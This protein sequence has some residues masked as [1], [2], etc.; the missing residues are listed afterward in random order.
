[1]PRELVPVYIQLPKE[2]NQRIIE[3]ARTHG[4]SKSAYIRQI[5]RIYL[6]YL[7]RKANPEREPIVDW[8]VRI[9]GV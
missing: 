3:L 4:Y 7:D 5:I 9:G 6:L 1:M 8:E 2:T